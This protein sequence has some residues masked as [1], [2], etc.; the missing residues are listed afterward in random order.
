MAKQRYTAQEV[1]DALWA[2]N[3]VVIRAANRLGC[4]P[5]TVYDYANR[6]VTVKDAMQEARR[7]TYAEAQGY[8]VAVPPHTRG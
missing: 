4:N 2:A 7:N 8:L 6:Y 5:S 1:I 3:G